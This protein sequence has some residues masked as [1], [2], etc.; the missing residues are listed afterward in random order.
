MARPR[1]PLARS[2]LIAAARRE[3]VRSGI[4]KARIE[5]ITHASGLSKGAFYLHFESK[6]ALFRELVDALE[7]QFERI[8][9]DR[10]FAYIEL[11]S[12]GM[13]GTGSPEPFITELRE[14]DV[15]ADLRV[16]EILWAWRDVVDVLLRGSQGTPFET[17]MWTMLD[18]EVER[19]ESSCLVLQRAGLLRDDVQ[20]ELFGWTMVGSFLL[21]TRRMLTLTQK[22]DF[23]PW[24]DSLHRVIGDGAISAGLRSQRASTARRATPLRA[25]RATSSLAARSKR[26]RR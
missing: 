13:P 7:A 9:T 3:F 8:H 4:Q 10:Q 5:D 20:P 12:R 26:R 1:D 21:M 16:L 6:E 25:S 17:V 18:R 22:P 23:Q 15:S 2:A 24:V 11:M 19:V 14:L